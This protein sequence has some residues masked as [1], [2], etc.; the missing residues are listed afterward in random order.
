MISENAKIVSK[1]PSYKLVFHFMNI[2]A[3]MQK[4][5]SK[6]QT[7]CEKVVD[8]MQV[9]FNPRMQFWDLTIFNTSP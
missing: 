5:S 2:D 8:H 7:A 9:G 3:K 4:L 1:K 6:T